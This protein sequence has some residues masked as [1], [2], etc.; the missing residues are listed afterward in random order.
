MLASRKK[1][2]KKGEMASKSNSVEW[3]ARAVPCAVKRGSEV[4]SCLAHG[5]SGSGDGIVDG[6]VDGWVDVGTFEGLG[7]ST[8]DAPPAFNLP[9]WLAVGR[10]LAVGGWQL[11]VRYRLILVFKVA[12]NCRIVQ[13][14]CAGWADNRASTGR[15]QAINTQ[16]IHQSAPSAWPARKDTRHD[17]E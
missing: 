2:N 9:K 14:A 3:G 12:T 16:S 4:C 11:I 1:R 6:W 15:I 13:Q 8:L 7:R 5:Q 10:Q 17:I